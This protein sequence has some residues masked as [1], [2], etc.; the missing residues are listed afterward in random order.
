VNIDLYGL[1]SSEPIKIPDQP[2]PIVFIWITSKID[3]A[4]EE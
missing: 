4:D 2:E 1:N 3:W